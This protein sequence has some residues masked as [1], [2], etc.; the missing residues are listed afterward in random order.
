[1]SSERRSARLLPPPAVARR[2]PC[3]PSRAVSRR[4]RQSA[5]SPGPPSRSRL[6]LRRR[7][8][9]GASAAGE[10]PAGAGRRGPRV[11]PSPAGT[12]RS[13]SR[14]QPRLPAQ[15]PDR[16]STAP[17][18]RRADRAGRSVSAPG[19]LPAL[20]CSRASSPRL[21]RSPAVRRPRW[22]LTQS[23]V[24]AWGGGCTFLGS[25]PDRRPRSCGFA[26]PRVVS[27]GL[28]KASKA[29]VVKRGKGWGMEIRWM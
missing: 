6:G 9:H 14:R 5:G 8:R 17:D 10:Q 1:M 15:H 20:A 26:S 27:Q 19:P 21:C 29:P 16:L 24:G 3:V 23:R 7:R 11:S 22:G 28:V 13:D 12:G 25:C 2:P 18:L 4:R